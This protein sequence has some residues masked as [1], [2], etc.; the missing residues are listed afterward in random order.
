MRGRPGTADLTPEEGVMADKV[1]EVI[2]A[3]PWELWKK[4]ALG[5]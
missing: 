5:K 2:S 4:Q 1:N 3:R